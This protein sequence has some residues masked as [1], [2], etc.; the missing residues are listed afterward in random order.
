MKK[1]ILAIV[2]TLALSTLLFSCTQRDGVEDNNAPT[3]STV[4]D[5]GYIY[6]AN[7][8]LTLIYDAES[9]NEDNAMLLANALFNVV[10]G[11]FQVGG[12]GSARS[13]HEIVIGKSDREISITA[14]RFL[15]RMDEVREETELRYL[16]Y[17]DG[18]S[19][20]FAYDDAYWGIGAA[21]SRAI[22]YFVDELICDSELKLKK[23]VIHKGVV[24]AIA[25]Q[26]A[27]DAVAVE[28]KWQQMEAIV[29]AKTSPE[30][31]KEF[32][33]AFKNMYADYSD[34]VVYWIAN[35]YDPETGGFYYSNSSRNTEGFLPD[36][37][38]TY[39][40]IDLP[41]GLG[42]TDGKS[43]AEF[44][45][46]EFG[47]RL[48][49]WVKGLQDPDNGYFYHPQWGKAF[50]DQI[51][52]RRGRD[53][54][55][56]EN[57]LK[58]F[59]SSPTY[60]TPN[61]VKGDGILAN[62]DRVIP[63]SK[64]QLTNKLSSNVITAV[65]K[66]I[67]VND[68]DA[69]VTPHLRNEQAFRKY[70]AG[71]DI[72]GNPYTIGN[73]LASQATQIPARDKV[74][75]ARGETYRLADIL[76]E[77]MNEHQNPDT[78]LW[79]LDG[80]VDYDAVNG[81]LKIGATYNFI[82]KEIPN[83]I[84]ALGSAIQC[85]IS[86]EKPDHI[87]DVLNPLYAISEIK[88][89]I[90]NYHTG[91]KASVQNQI[92]NATK[93]L[94]EDATKIVEV[95]HAK[96]AIFK[97]QDGSY[98]YWP[99]QTACTSQGA[100]VALVNTNEG[101][102][103]TVNIAMTAI[104][105]HLCSVLG[106]GDKPN[107]CTKA[108]GVRYLAILS[109]LG[110]VIKDKPD[111]ERDTAKGKYVRTYGGEFYPDSYRTQQLLNVYRASTYIA[112]NDDDISTQEQERIRLIEDELRLTG[113][114]EYSK[115]AS[116][117][118]HGFVVRRTG[119]Q[120][121]G[122]CF[123]FET[124]IKIDRLDDEAMAAILEQKQ[125]ILLNFTAGAIESETA[126]KVSTCDWAGSLGAVYLEKREDGY[127][128]YFS[129]ASKPYQYISYGTNEYRGKKISADD[130]FTVT[131]E[132][133]DNGIAKYYINNEYFEEARI[134]DDTSEFFINLD[135]VKIN[136]GYYA[137]NSSVWIDNT[138]V[139]TV[140]KDYEEGEGMRNYDYIGPG[141]YGVSYGGLDFDVETIQPL[142]RKGYITRATWNTIAGEGYSYSDTSFHREFIRISE[143]I[144]DEKVEKVL[145]FG[146]RTTNAKGIYLR[147]TNPG[148]GN[149]FVFESE[150][151]LDIDEKT[152]INMVKNGAVPIFH[153]HI[154]K[155]VASASVP[156]TDPNYTGSE[157]ARIYVNKDSS[158][159]LRYYVNA[160]VAKAYMA[161]TS[162]A[163]ITEGWHTFTMEIY[164][165]GIVKYYVDG[166]LLGEA[167][168]V[169]SQDIAQLA[170][171]NSI[172]LSIEDALDNSYFF[173]DNTYITRMNKPYAPINPDTGDDEGGEDS[174][175][176]GDIDSPFDGDNVSGG[177]WS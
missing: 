168:T 58:M 104:P 52:A 15:N 55:W 120:N 128:S 51:P 54:Q 173:L 73:L 88:K 46:E 100:T 106:I 27:I 132:L 6:S 137:T 70:L 147:E 8:D 140:Q 117:S 156:A 90:N 49:K 38:S 97:K 30:K 44:Y 25:W 151:M 37:E 165:N 169:S 176:A 161:C 102:A 82:Q 134:F 150:F 110:A 80:S 171:M 40:L 23:G 31:A 107:V 81:L 47:E 64:L 152:A 76:H 7:S 115:Y 50:T 119:A 157:L 29:A 62:G 17:S 22:E 85:L 170:D 174:G 4:R 98:S 172:K 101:D 121:G 114:L 61:G 93:R 127:Y 87:C 148:S 16:I 158:G 41:R 153:F 143:V 39:Q 69:N 142:Q 33:T 21:E 136:F 36:L 145:E 18:N 10:S 131:V 42:M 66:V 108:D 129:H 63:A 5:D 155:S 65:S 138:F 28:E 79:D 14:Y 95:T 48:V 167:K 133:Y 92:N 91:D 96:M 77:W 125:P 43:T 162:A 1:T 112:C 116:P 160:P 34:D 26:E 78:G 166:N 164:E 154:G 146:A 2:F 144:R 56:A 86:E 67:L 24:D 84:P 99:E 123:V 135:A 149:C 60:D 59:G 3:D 12:V 75:A 68:A 111:D 124:E 130:W 71:L 53:L 163:E 74:L 9:V 35:L 57:L 94:L 177:G 72:N 122:N 139:G 113:V 109:D 13:A 11:E 32:V 45:P 19:V 103:N 126:A 105:G 20:A 89:N 159:N 83:V 141:N 118:T 175:D